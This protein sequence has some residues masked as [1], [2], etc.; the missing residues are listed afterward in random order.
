[1]VLYNPSLPLFMAYILRSLVDKSNNIASTT[2]PFTPAAT[3]TDLSLLIFCFLL[4]AY[5][6]VHGFLLPSLFSCHLIVSA[7]TLYFSSILIVIA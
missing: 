1:M 5:L 3:D 4:I 7:I 2:L 6:F